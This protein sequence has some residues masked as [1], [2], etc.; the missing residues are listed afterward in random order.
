MSACRSICQ[1]APSTIPIK[2]ILIQLLTTQTMCCFQAHLVTAN[3]IA[4]QSLQQP[5]VGMVYPLIDVVFI[6]V[7]PLTHSKMIMLNGDTIR[8]RVPSIVDKL[9][10][11]VCF[12]II[13]GQV[14]SNYHYWQLLVS[15]G[16]IASH[17]FQL[18]LNYEKGIIE[19]L[20][21]IFFY[22]LSFIYMST[23]LSITDTA[24]TLSLITIHHYIEIY[25]LIYI[26]I[27]SMN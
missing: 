19:W 13:I 5:Q 7:V 14:T 3:L 20:L 21:G 23:S 22:V 16:F 18:I 4:A 24:E 9:F 27:I 6:D 1:D 26:S 8:S 17:S 2:I 11:C 15:I 25:L 10:C 12:W